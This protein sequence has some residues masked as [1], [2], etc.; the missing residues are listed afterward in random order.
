MYRGECRTLSGTSVAA[1]VVTGVI[2][3]LLSS[4][5]QQDRKIMNPASVKQVLMDSADQIVGANMFEQGRGSVN[6]VNAYQ[7]NEFWVLTETNILQ[8]NLYQLP[9]KNCF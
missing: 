1:P 4:L 2:A 5:N 8:R 6:L 9:W 3:L 7:V